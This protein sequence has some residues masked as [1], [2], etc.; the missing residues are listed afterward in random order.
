MRKNGLLKA[1]TFPICLKAHHPTM[2]WFILWKL[3]WVALRQWALAN[4]TTVHVRACCLLLLDAWVCL[5]PEEA[6][7]QIKCVQCSFEDWKHCSF[8]V[9]SHQTWKKGK[10]QLEQSLSSCHNSTHGFRL[11]ILRYSM[12]DDK[13]AAES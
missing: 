2:G 9:S 6:W 11:D 7:L 3:H 4:K 5:L 10:D 12:F 13:V 8:G 1:E